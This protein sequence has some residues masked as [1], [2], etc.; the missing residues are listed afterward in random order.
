VL[1]TLWAAELVVKHRFKEIE[2]QAGGQA[3]EDN[4]FVAYSDMLRTTVHNPF[5]VGLIY[6]RVIGI[7]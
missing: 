6:L 1:G 7:G 2:S 5:S 3:D 4:S